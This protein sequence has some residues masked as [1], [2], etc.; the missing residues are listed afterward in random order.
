MFRKSFVRYQLK[1]IKKYKL[2][3]TNFDSRKF[4]G[5]SYSFSVISNR[6]ISCDSNVFNF[7]YLKPKLQ[8][9]NRLKIFAPS[10]VYI[11]GVDY[12][13][14]RRGLRVLSLCMAANSSLY[15]V[16][17]AI[18]CIR[19]RIKHHSKSIFFLHFAGTNGSPLWQS[20]SFCS[21]T[22][23]MHIVCSAVKYIGFRR[24]ATRRT[25]FYEFSSRA[26]ILKVT[27]TNIHFQHDWLVTNTFRI[28]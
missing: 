5:I 11:R 7:L 8:I 10:C 13:G 25:T 3:K 14:R 18:C 1:H 26:R 2:L 24:F 19:V 21:Q 17:S 20:K 9:N 4:N 23:A 16:C 6:K 27:T 15:Y 22:L 12:V 28:K